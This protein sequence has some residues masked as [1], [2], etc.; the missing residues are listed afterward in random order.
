MGSGLFRG[1]LGL[2]RGALRGLP[3]AH[4]RRWIGDQRGSASTEYAMLLGVMGVS[5]IAA[6]EG[7][8]ESVRSIVVAATAALDSLLH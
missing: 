6:W 5:T 8:G 1:M 4:L 2:S 7:L 3:V